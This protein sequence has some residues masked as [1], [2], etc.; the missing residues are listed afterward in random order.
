MCKYLNTL[1]VKQK[2]MNTLCELTYDVN[3]WYNVCKENSKIEGYRK[4]RLMEEIKE[5]K[6]YLKEY[7][8]N[9]RKLKEINEVLASISNSVYKYNK[10]PRKVRFL[11]PDTDDFRNLKQEFMSYDYMLLI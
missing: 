1:E 10:E 9:D 4:D 8:A 5:Y 6:R 3:F 2:I 7:K 11:I